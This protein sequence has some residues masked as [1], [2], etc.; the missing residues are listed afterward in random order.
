M[1]LRDRVALVT[2]GGTGFGR[3]IA[4]R[5]ASEGARVVVSGRRSE[6]LEA[7]VAAIQK[8]G[9]EALAIVCDATV[10]R[11][12]E[13]MVRGATERFGA[14]D[15][16]VN[17]AGAVFGRVTVEDCGEE[18][19]RQTLE[20]NLMTVFLCSRA[21]LP[22]LRRR[23]G[24]II[25]IASMGGLKPQRRHAPYSVAK[26]AVVHL[27]KCMAL[28]HADE[29]VRV[30]C[31]CPAYIETDMNREHLRRLRETGEIVELEKAHP[32]GLRGRPEDVA[33]AATYLASN[34][35]HWNTGCCLPVD[36]GVSA[37]I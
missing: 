3:A 15:I 13:T 24:S 25:N 4:A 21:A 17:N 11:D 36:G 16:L 9:G 32:L 26:A 1:R 22:E 6:Q 10:A 34:E 8:A 37:T 5:F 18:E 7:T 2:G 35:A 12:V 28:D 30:N 19:F 33:A 20:V 27:T 23:R 29:G 14:L 31:I